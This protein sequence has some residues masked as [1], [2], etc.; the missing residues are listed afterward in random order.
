MERYGCRRTVLTG[1]EPLLQADD[2]L[3]GALKKAGY[4]IAVETNGSLP[5]PEGIDWVTCSPKLPPW[6]I[7][8]IDELKIVYQGQNPEAL[9]Q[10]L[11]EASHYFLQPCSGL[12]TAETVDY[13]LKHPKWR[14]SLQTHKL[15]DIR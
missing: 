9:A 8:R 4:H 6:N 2:A 11:P 7:N 14:L 13:I 5:V 3:I 15:I 10:Q 12:N 1:G